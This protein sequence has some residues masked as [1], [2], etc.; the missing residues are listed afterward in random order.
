MLIFYISV[1]VVVTLGLVVVAWLVH[2]E[3]KK[4]LT[5]KG[6]SEKKEQGDLLSRLGLENPALRS[7]TPD[8]FLDIKQNNIQ[9][10][11]PEQLSI[12]ENPAKD[13]NS[14]SEKSQV[15]LGPHPS[16]LS[17][18]SSSQEDLN[19]K[20]THLEQLFQ[21]KSLELEKVLK[22]L[23]I[24][25]KTHKEFN[26]VKDILE[27]E[28]KDKKDQN[29]QLQ[30]ELL[31]SQ[32]EAQTFLKRVN[33]L[34]EKIKT[35][36]NEIKDKEAEIKESQHSKEIDQ[37]SIQDLNQEIRSKNATIQEK[38]TK[39]ADW[40]KKL[41]SSKPAEIPH[42]IES[43]NSPANPGVPQNSFSKSSQVELNIITPVQ[44]ISSPSDPINSNLHEIPENISKLKELQPDEFIEDDKNI[45][46]GIPSSTIATPE[47][48]REKD[49]RE[50]SINPESPSQP[51]NSN[52]KE[53]TQGERHTQ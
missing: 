26:K 17:I 29:R 49:S 19:I 41:N 44:N 27:K 31:N 23:S 11:Q 7:E 12:P 9:Q 40:I 46:E 4:Q 8:S 33:Q 25:N 43:D 24:E 36:E 20:Y 1:I 5:Q 16:N 52:K 22:S 28:I 37:K 51:L 53:D 32:T 47:E 30:M 45:R 39:I 3:Q 6:G 18:I 35:L 15:A 48:G 21:E 10:L 38:D 34:E 50:L 14:I 13:S 42:P 2:S